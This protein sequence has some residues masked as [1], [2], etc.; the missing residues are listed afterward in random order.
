MMQ[1]RVGQVAARLYIF[2]LFRS[3]KYVYFTVVV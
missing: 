2:P 1:Y 3:E